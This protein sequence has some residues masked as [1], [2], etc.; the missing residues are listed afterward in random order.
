MNLIADTNVLVRALVA[1]E[2]KQAA[3]AQKLLS[4]ASLVAISSIV[5]CELHWVLSRAYKVSNTDIEAAI[6]ALVNAVNVHTD[7]AAVEAGLTFMKSGGDFADGVLWHLGRKLGGQ[8]FAS[9][10]KKAV[11]IVKAING[12]VQLL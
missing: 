6:N 1:D 10:D 7:I 4:E 11:K 2:P 3:T 9:F 12:N 5:F 8:T